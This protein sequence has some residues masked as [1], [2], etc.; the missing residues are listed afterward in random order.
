MIENTCN[1]LGDGDTWTRFQQPSVINLLWFSDG[2][3]YIIAAQNLAS[4]TASLIAAIKF[5]GVPAHR[6]RFEVDI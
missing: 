1:N 4:L 5:A 3:H 2:L 6:A